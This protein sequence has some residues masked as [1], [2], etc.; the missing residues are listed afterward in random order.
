MSETGR[1]P[2]KLWLEDDRPREKL[3]IKGPAALSDAELIAILINIGTRE[4]SALDLAQEILNKAE[5]NLIELSRL[6]VKD[7]LKFKGIGE[8]KAITIAAAL[9]LGKRRRSSEILDRRTIRS[10]HD[11]FELLQEKLADLNEERFCIILLNRANRVLNV[12]MVSTGGFAGT[13]ADPKKI[14][15]IALDAKASSIILGHNHPSGMTK[16]SEADNKLTSK[17]KSSGDIL[18]LPVLDHIIVG[19][20]KYFSYADEGMM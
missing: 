5:G 11:A 4:L 19:D 14:F 1:T 20:E 9:E 15:K 10:S 8:A 18:D 7:L 2:I 12:E 16:P 17:L 6:S 13:V 3:L